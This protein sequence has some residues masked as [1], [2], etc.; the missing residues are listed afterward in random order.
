M[1]RHTFSN[2]EIAHVWAHQQQESGRNSNGTIFFEGPWIYSYGHHFPMAVLIGDHD[3]IISKATYSSTTSNHKSLVRQATR[4]LTQTFV[5]SLEYRDSWLGIMQRLRIQCREQMNQ[6]PEIPVHHYRRLLTCYTALLDARQTMELLVQ[7]ARFHIGATDH[8]S[9]TGDRNDLD[10]MIIILNEVN[11]TADR[12]LEGNDESINEATRRAREADAR[13]TRD[14]RQG[15]TEEMLTAWWAGKRRRVPNLHFVSEHD[16][17]RFDRND[18]V[19]TTSQ[20]LSVNAE[21]VRNAWPLIQRAYRRFD[22]SG[23]VQLPLRDLQ[24]NLAGF[25]VR[26]IDRN[27]R[28]VVGCHVF[29]RDN[30]FRVARDMGLIME[31]EAS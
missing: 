11:A 16:L 25:P 17:L 30:I 10:R 22:G 23:Q 26:E 19:L 21:A 5:P 6:L 24:L 14:R 1:A 28:L 31:K 3:V 13:N 4:H 12:V 9:I 18:D 7:K 20:G 15:P 8:R 2:N 27:A 29:T